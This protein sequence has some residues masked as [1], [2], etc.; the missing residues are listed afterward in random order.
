MFF[1]ILGS[2]MAIMEVQRHFIPIIIFSIFILIGNPLIV[3]ILMGLFGYTKRTSFLA[4]LTVAQ[5]SEFSLILVALGIKV[6]HLSNETL[7]LVATVGLIT[8]AGSTYMI[9]YSNQLY[10]KLSKYLGIFERKKI[11]EE[12]KIKKKYDAILFGYNRIGFSILRSL[13]KIKKN[14]LVI[15]F[16]P[17]VVSNLS[18][19]GIP[20]LYGDID[21]VDFL[22]ELPLNKIELAVSTVPDFE[23]NALLI[24]SIRL[25]NKDAIIIVRSHQIKDA[26]TLYNKGASYVLTPHFLGGE[27]VARMIREEKVNKL[28]YKEEKEKHI[29]MLKSMMS[30]GHKHPKVED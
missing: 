28:K 1:I 8:I 30:R 20:C 18:K 15:D 23:T 17:E 12:R 29:N 11:K 6:G 27:Y 25:V 13:K 9:I 22:N 4:G 26:L 21:D 10:D 19:W 5:I 14:Y 2:Q 7:S 3:M 16:N 24:E